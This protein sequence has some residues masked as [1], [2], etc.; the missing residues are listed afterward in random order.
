MGHKSSLFS[1]V[2]HTVSQWALEIYS[3][4]LLPTQQRQTLSKHCRTIKE[5]VLSH[6]TSSHLKT[7]NESNTNK[8]KYIKKPGEKKSA[9]DI[10]AKATCKM[11]SVGM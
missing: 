7:D 5:E 2:S 8:V 3:Q 10:V 1:P 6:L 4:H 11:C 9:P